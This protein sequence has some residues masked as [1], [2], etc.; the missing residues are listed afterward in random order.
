MNKLDYFDENGFVTVKNFLSK[1]KCNEIIDK[2]K[3]IKK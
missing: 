1:K 3:N 2:L